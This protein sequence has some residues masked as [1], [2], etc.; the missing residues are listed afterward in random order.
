MIYFSWNE[1]VT[2]PVLFSDLPRNA[3]LALTIYDCVGSC[4]TKPVGGTTISLFGKHGVFRQGM[5][6]LKVWPDQEADGK[7]PSQTPGK[8]KDKGKVQMQRLAKVNI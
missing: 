7:C 8:T 6:D 1:W 5:L 2:L 4:E 3:Q